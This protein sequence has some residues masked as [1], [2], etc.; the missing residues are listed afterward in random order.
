[1][2]YLKLVAAN[3]RSY[4]IPDYV[5]LFYFIVFLELTKKCGDENQQALRA[6]L[7][8]ILKKKAQQK[9]HMQ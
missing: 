1:M 5:N 3:E 4:D 8:L 6:T 2:V 9:L 7:I